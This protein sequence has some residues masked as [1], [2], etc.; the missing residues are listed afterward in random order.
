MKRYVLLAVFLPV[1]LTAGCG[2][3]NKAEQMY[4][5]INVFDNVTVEI[6]GIAPCAKAEVK[7]LEE[8]PWYDEKD[9]S[10]SKSEEIKNGDIIT[11]SCNITDETF[12]ENG[13][14]RVL[15]EKTYIVPE[16]DMYIND[17][18]QLSKETLSDIV[19]E[20]F[21]LLKADTE[22]SQDRML[23]RITG[24]ANYLFQYNKEWLEQAEVCKI[25]LCTPTDYQ[26]DSKDKN[27]VYV[28]LKV[29]AANSDYKEEGY[30]AFEYKNVVL[31]GGGTLYTNYGTEKKEYITMSD[32]EEL[33][34][35]LVE[36]KMGEYYVG[37]SDGASF[38]KFEN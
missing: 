28:F 34:K 13:Y 16:F 19:N 26:D 20:E 32:Y 3:G 25:A 33:Y 31:T 5:K 2:R 27:I 17:M 9:F 6:S 24:N 22:S 29:I 11:V 37:T 10:L 4:E 1:L 18:Q 15:A 14:E 7:L 35:M 8:V 30:A 23:Y 38:D 36:P 12:N 21:Q